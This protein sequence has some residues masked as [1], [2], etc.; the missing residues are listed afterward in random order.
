MSDPIYHL[1]QLAR[2]HGVSRNEFVRSI[3][4]L[5]LDIRVRQTPINPAI[6]DSFGS[7]EMAKK[8]VDEAVA[9]ADALKKVCESK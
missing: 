9:F 2:E 1:P 5:L 6:Y 8:A 4:I 3:A 7:G